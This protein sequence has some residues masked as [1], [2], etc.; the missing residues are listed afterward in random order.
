MFLSFFLD[1]VFPKK[2]LA[3][4]QEGDFLCDRCFKMIGMKRF[5]VC[6]VC[7]KSSYQGKTHVDSCSVKTYLNGL[8]VSSSYHENPVLEK[9]IKQ[10]KYHYS[11]DLQ[12]KLGALLAQVLQR[13]HFSLAGYCIVPV[14]LHRKREKWRGFNQAK[15]LAES[16]QS[17][18]SCPLGSVLQRMKYTKQQA[19]SS[20]GERLENM[21]DA[22]IVTGNIVPERVLLVDDVSST[23]ITLDEAAKVLKKAGCK[24]V[25]GC[26]LARG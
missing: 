25:Y 2:C 4:K 21:K 19:K 13:N 17:L 22:F 18:I 6:P 26:V 5:Q 11:K 8:L 10:F 16:L 24:E 20:R 14:P 15:L 9:T 1:L 7:K 12:K 23:L 3:C